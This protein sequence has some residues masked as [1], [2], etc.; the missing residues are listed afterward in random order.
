MENVWYLVKSVQFQSG[1]FYEI[2]KKGIHI[3]EEV[4]EFMENILNSNIQKKN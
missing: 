2:N 1:E 3:L 4:Y